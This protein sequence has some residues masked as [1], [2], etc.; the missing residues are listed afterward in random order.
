MSEAPVN[1]IPFI[2][3]AIRKIE[4]IIANP[5]ASISYLLISFPLSLDRN[6]TGCSRQTG[7]SIG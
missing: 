7:E 5:T 2:P 3:K 6:T 4:L 1:Q